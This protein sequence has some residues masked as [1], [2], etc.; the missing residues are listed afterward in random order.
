MNSGGSNQRELDKGMNPNWTP[1]SKYIVYSK[2]QKDDRRR[3]SNYIWKISI[4]GKEKK[5]ITN[6]KNL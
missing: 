3:S 6:N 1:D 5:Q 4:D 2:S